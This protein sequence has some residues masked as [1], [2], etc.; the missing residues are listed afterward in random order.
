MTT[1]IT[2]FS[3]ALI[4]WAQQCTKMTALLSHMELA[5]VGSIQSTIFHEDRPDIS[6]HRVLTSFN[7]VYQIQIEKT[8]S[9]EQKNLH[10]PPAWRS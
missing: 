9:Q 4:S 7:E 1:N 5:C 2:Y 3:K 10:R 8:E 6:S